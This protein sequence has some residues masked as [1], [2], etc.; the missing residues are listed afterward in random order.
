MMGTMKRWVR[1]TKTKNV[2][3]S[4]ELAAMVQALA[5]DRERSF[6][7]QARFMLRRIMEWLND[8]KNDKE[9]EARLDELEKVESNS[10]AKARRKKFRV[11]TGSTEKKMT[12]TRASS[13]RRSR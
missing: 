10:Q 9:F 3:L 8:P 11:L 12:P 7:A 5:E 13:P 1:L 4:P 6:S 2:K